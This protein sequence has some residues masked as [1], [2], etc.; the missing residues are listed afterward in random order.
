M[1]KWTRAGYLTCGTVSLSGQRREAG[2][3]ASRGF[4]GPRLIVV[5]AYARLLRRGTPPPRTVLL[6]GGPWEG[7]MLLTRTGLMPE[8]IKL[9]AP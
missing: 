7:R 8:E 3:A 4:C 9:A 5:I 6:I 1:L 2:H